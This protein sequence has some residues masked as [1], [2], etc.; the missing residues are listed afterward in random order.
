MSWPNGNWKSDLRTAVTSPYYWL[1]YACLN[2]RAF[3]PLNVDWEL[4]FRCNLRCRICPQELFKSQGGKRRTPS[5][6]AELSLD[7]AKAVVDDLATMGVKVITLTGGEPLLYPQAA[8]IAHYIKAR[9]MAC[10]IL[11][12][13]GVM[14]EEIARRLVQAKVDALTFSLDGPQKVHDLVRGRE[15]CFARLCQAVELVQKLKVSEGSRLPSLAFN[16]T[17]S[18]LNQDCFSELLE[19]A[20]RLQVPAVN[21]AY[22][23]FTSQKA[24]SETGRLIDLQGVK[25]ENQV[26]PDDLKTIDPET[27]KAQIALSCEQASKYKLRVNFF[28]PLQGEEIY[29]YFSDDS[30]SYCSKC[31]FP[32]Y[33]GRINPYGAVYPCSIDYCI[34]NVRQQP[35]SSL[36]NSQAYRRFRRQLKSLRLFPKCKKCCMLNNKLWDILPAL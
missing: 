24:V 10:N 17:I 30:Y 36:W 34:G 20:D 8:E 15:G 16:C 21:F 3:S 1:A 9:G 11:T 5:A 13:G 12:N 27:V 33:A 25:Q 19:I 32:W 35:F 14:S 23:F 6:E 4:T 31:F 2:G 29:R 18:A 28:P 26:L 7:E 22:L